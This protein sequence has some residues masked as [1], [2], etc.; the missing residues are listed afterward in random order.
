MT[1]A[2]DKH[3]YTHTVANSRPIQLTAYIKRN[4]CILGY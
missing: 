1:P 4:Y 2:N 3:K